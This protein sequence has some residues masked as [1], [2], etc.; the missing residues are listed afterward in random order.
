MALERLDSW[1]GR[2][3]R[4]GLSAQRVLP[5]V[6]GD[7]S[8]TPPG[9]R[10]PRHPL[11]VWWLL[12]EHDLLARCRRRYGPVFSLRAWPLGFMSWSP[13]RPRSSG[14]SWVIPRCFTPAR[15]TG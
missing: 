1:Y 6:P 7:L 9:P 14:C 5:Q 2:P 11:G 4:D 13:I 3:G 8:G 12:R 15:A 10:L